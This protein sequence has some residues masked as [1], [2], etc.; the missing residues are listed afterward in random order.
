MS[1]GKY[2]TDEVYVGGKQGA[3]SGSGSVEV[4]IDVTPDI[5][6]R[7]ELGETKGSNIGVIYKFDY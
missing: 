7:T 1:A 2:V 3:A 4:E 5:A 6:V